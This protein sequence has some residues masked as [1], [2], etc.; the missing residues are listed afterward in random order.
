[1]V[2]GAE[3]YAVRDYI[4]DKIGDK[5]FIPL[6]CHTDNSADIPPENQPDYPFIIKTNHGGRGEITV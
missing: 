2:K 4:K 1:M 5:Y 6:V 3:K